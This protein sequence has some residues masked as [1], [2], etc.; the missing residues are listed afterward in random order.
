VTAPQQIAIPPGMVCI[1]THGHIA[2]QTAQMW[3]D[4]RS[5]AERNGLTNVAWQ[6]VPGT[7]VEKARNDAVR[8]MLGAFNGSGQWLLYV[9]GDMT[10][11]P[12]SLQKI[13]V[14]AYGTHTWADCVGGYCTL[15]GGLALPTMDT[16]T[17]TWESIYPNSGVR[18][19]MR[20]GAAFLLVKRH[21]FE[22]LREPWFRV[23]QPMRVLDALAEIDNFARIHFNGRNPLRGLQGKPWETMENLASGEA[24]NYVPVEVGEDSGFCDRAKNAGLRIVVDTSIVVGHL[25]TH[26]V[27]WRTHKEAMEKHRT[28]FR[29]AVGVA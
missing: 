17:G 9:D 7:L 14:T 3:S 4:M 19:V 24:A 18:E 23:R 1:T 8:S 21:V 5:H 6:I 13:L 20:T 26:V 29:Q 2:G 27:D 16:G 12:E 22:R 15:R 11:A 28:Q 10:F 25:D